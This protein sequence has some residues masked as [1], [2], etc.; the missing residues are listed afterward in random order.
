MFSIETSSGKIIRGHSYFQHEDEIILP[1]GRYLRVVDKSSPAHDLHIIHLREITPPYPMLVPPFDLQMSRELSS[2]KP[3][4]LSFR[5]IREEEDLM[6]PSAISKKPT[7][8]PSKKGK[9]FVYQLLHVFRENYLQKNY[10]KRFSRSKYCNG[11]QI[12]LIVFFRCLKQEKSPP[13]YLITVE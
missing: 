11:D 12:F 5:I 10:L 9:F 3:S 7:L 2:S 6:T 13:Q 8:V 4:V 1:P